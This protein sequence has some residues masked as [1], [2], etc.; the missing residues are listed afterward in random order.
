[1]IQV[2]QSLL[3]A[4][5]PVAVEADTQR[6]TKSDHNDDDDAEEEAPPLELAGTTSMVC[7]YLDL[8]ITGLH[9]VDSIFGVL[10]CGY[11]SFVLLLDHGGKFLVQE[12]NFGKV[13]LQ[14]LQVLMA[15]ANITEYLSG[16]FTTVVHELTE[17]S[18]CEISC[19]EGAKRKCM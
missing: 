7:C 1:M 4:A 19:E 2:P 5:T 9:V 3:A 8:L 14:T 18:A 11:D 12:G 6:N 15:S 10:L 13:L 17:L 16:L